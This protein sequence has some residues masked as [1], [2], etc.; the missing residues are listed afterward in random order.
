MFDIPVQPNP[1][2]LRELSDEAMENILHPYLFMLDNSGRMAFNPIPP[3]TLAELDPPP[4]FYTPSDTTTP[5]HLPPY[6]I[7]LR[8]SNPLPQS[9]PFTQSN[10]SSNEEYEEYNNL[11]LV[12]FALM[13]LDPPAAGGAMDLTIQD[14]TYSENE[15]RLIDVE[16]REREIVRREIELQALGGTFADSKR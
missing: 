3:T 12:N 8:P 2:S 7:A 10:S 13:D 4:L 9:N 1:G 16:R 6:S 5:R 11:P 14:V 15:L